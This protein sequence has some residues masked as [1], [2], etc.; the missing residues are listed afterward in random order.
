[1]TS[2][3]VGS[4]T[5]VL[6][7]APALFVGPSPVLLFVSSRVSV[8]ERGTLFSSYLTVDSVFVSRL[9]SADTLTTACPGPSTVV[10]MFS[11]FLLK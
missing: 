2:V 10:S 7:V 8:V 11:T 1:M 9:I 6:L 3:F 5:V 4:V